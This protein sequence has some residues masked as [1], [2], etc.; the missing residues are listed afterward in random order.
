MFQT[1]KQFNKEKEKNYRLKICYNEQ[2]QETLGV[3]YFI[4]FIC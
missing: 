3:E 2:F 4:A 1:Q